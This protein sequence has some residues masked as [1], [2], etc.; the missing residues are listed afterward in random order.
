[1]PDGTPIPNGSA[2]ANDGVELTSINEPYYYWTGNNESTI[3]PIT[4]II[5]DPFKFNFFTENL[6]MNKVAT[7]NIVIAYI[8]ETFSFRIVLIKY[9]N[10][11]INA[12]GGTGNP[13]HVSNDLFDVS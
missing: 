12:D 11:K 1:M 4:I 7:I 3:N 13:V 2:F 6:F 5:N 10:G 9:T 8:I